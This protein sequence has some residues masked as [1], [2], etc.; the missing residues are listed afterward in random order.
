MKRLMLI[1]AIAAILLPSAALAQAYNYGGGGG[2]SGADQSGFT[3]SI[4]AGVANPRNTD[5]IV[6]AS[7]PNVVIP[8]WDDE[9][10][11]RLGVRYGFEGGQQIEFRFWS[12][13]TDTSSAALGSFEFPIGPIDGFSY[14]V[15]TEIEATTA[16]LS[17]GV[18]HQFGENFTLEWFL[19]LAYADF[20]ET[21]SG[22]YGTTSGTLT[23]YKSNE[24]TML[25]ARTSSRASYRRGSLSGEVG[26]SIA[27]LDGEIKARSMLTPQPGG[28]TAL[29]LTDDS[30]SGNLFE[31]DVRG[32]WHSSDDSWKVWLGWEQQSWDDIAAD[33]ARNLPGSAIITRDRDSVRFSWLKL[34]AS[35]RF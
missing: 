35:Y 6:A 21:T 3:V 19:G 30:R 18:G 17:W 24:A 32:T 4:E 2:L 27:M 31:M 34:G 11:G 29:N 10:A 14:D 5:N 13:D 16:D 33:L 23:P 1:S 28:T 7:G 26:F 8:S 20:Q 15:T 22:L 25:G 12:Y 9:F